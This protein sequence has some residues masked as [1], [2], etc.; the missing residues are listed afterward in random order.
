MPNVYEQERELTGEVAS[1][2]GRRLPEVEVLA[3]ELVSPRR[4]CVYVDHPQGV[5]H[6]LCQ[7]VTDLLRGYLD[8]YSVD[9]SSPGIERPLRTP[10]HFRGAVGHKVALRTGS[11]VDG[12]TRF[13]GRVVEA[14]D[15]A[16]KVETDGGETLVPYA[17]IVRGNL[18]DEDAWTS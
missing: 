17:E 5:D 15:D 8:R 2:I 13:R 3:V 11:T 4:F 1:A 18:T 12:R 14:G 6:A 9:V 7:R 10:E 16:V